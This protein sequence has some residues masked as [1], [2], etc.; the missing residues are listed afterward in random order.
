MAIYFIKI[1]SIKIA[2]DTFYHYL[3]AQLKGREHTALPKQGANIIAELAQLVEQL[4]R[5]E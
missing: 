2:S 1:R 5:N 4:I 3:C